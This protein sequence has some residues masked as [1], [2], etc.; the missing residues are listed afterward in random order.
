MTPRDTSPEA[1]AASQ[2]AKALLQ[3]AEM[4]AKEAWLA[5]PP[6]RRDTAM[7]KKLTMGTLLGVMVQRF[8]F[9]RDEVKLLAEAG[10]TLH[11]HYDSMK[12][13]FNV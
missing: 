3:Y 10:A 5:L 7:L 2:G 12:D 4:C 11:Q 13:V 8:K 9:N 6:H 1:E